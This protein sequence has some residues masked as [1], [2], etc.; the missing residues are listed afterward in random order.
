MKLEIAA[1]AAAVLSGGILFASHQ[2]NRVDI[3]K[4]DTAP[5]KV[6]TVPAFEYHVV[7]QKE[8][9]RIYRANGGKTGGGKLFGFQ[10]KKADGTVVV[11]TTQP[12]TVDDEATCTLGHE[13][14]HII[15]GKYH[16]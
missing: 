15:W 1:V 6:Y 16:E 9:S 4:A 14:Q 13:V 12:R 5:P 8:L 11:F 10:G 7:S 2:T 3:I